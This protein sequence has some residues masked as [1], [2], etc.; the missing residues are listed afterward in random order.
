MTRI[1][2]VLAAVLLL[3]RP[4]AAETLPPGVTST[5]KAQI[6]GVIG[7]QLE[8]F[9]HD[10]AAG[11]YRFAAPGIQRMFPSADTF[12]DMVRRGYPPVY[13]ARNTEFSELALRDGELVQEVEI[14]GP[15]GKPV[16]AVYSMV[17]DGHG[18]WLIN[19][20]T[21][22]PSVRLST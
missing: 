10:D 18:G 9:R 17:R 22:L 13:R 6:E 7:R 21:L 11:A 3:L 20:C 4:A 19:G 12:L 2:L 16:V 15:D 14:V 8:A 5:D 1:F